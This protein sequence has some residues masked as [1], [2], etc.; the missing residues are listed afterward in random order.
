M[1]SVGARFTLT[2]DV[3]NFYPSIYTHAV[4]WAVRGKAV[5]KR[6]QSAKSVGGRLDSLLRVG[7][8]GQTVGISIGPDTSWIVSEMVLARVDAALQR[9]CKEVTGH[10]LRWVDDMVFYAKSHGLAEDVLGIY[11]EELGEFELSLNPLKT[12]IQPGIKP[13]QDEWL[14]RLRQ[15]RYRDDTERHQADDI[16]DL[17]SLAFEM[18][19]RMP[20]SGAISYAIKRCNPFPSGSAWAM[21]QELLLASMA[22][23]SSSIRHVYDVMA[24]GRAVGLPINSAAFEEACSDLILRHAPLGHGFEVAWLLLILRELRID[25]SADSVDAALLMNC[26]ASNLLAWAAVEESTALTMA[27]RNLDSVVKRAESADALIS[28]DWLL[29]Y[30]ARAR[31]W[32]AP[33]TWGKSPAWRELSQKKVLFMELPD[34]NSALNQQQLIRRLRPAFVSSWGS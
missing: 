7:R 27:N 5:A 30:E 12:S 28:E 20:A 23:E 24:Y 29:A 33:K 21:F 11:E 26:N 31:K 13:Y 4:D 18:Q 8:G 32:C 15:A 3:S 34:R 10:A 25:P 6:D 1:R 16:V 14:I 17:F 2:T 22:L 19:A 9:R